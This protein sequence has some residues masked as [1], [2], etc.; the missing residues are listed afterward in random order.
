MKYFSESEFTMGGLN[1]FDKMD[2]NFLTKLDQ[3]RE[4]CGFPLTINSSYRSPEYNKSVGGAK[5]SQHLYGNAV[6]LRCT[7]S[8]KRAVIVSNALA[9]GLSVGITKSFVHVDNRDNQLMFVY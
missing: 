4:L 2:F 8:T 7:D 9:L 6:D 5:T 1:V 3:L